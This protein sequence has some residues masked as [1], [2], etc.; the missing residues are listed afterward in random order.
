MAQE[1]VDGEVRKVDKSG[2][3]L[4]IRHAPIPSLEMPAMTMSFHVKDASALKTLREGDKIRFRA[5]KFGD[6]YTVTR[7]EK[8]K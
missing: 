1:M 3:K 5:E 2:Q 8:A 6:R 7:I 4:T